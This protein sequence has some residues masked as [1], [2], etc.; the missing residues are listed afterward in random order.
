MNILNFDKGLS[1]YEA[2]NTFYFDLEDIATNLGYA[3]PKTA[4]QDF[5]RR[6]ADFQS[7]YV[8]HVDGRKLYDESTIYFFL[9]VSTQRDARE[10]LKYICLEVLPYV[11]QVGV[12]A[13]KGEA[14]RQLL[15]SNT[16]TPALL[17]DLEI[18]LGDEAEQFCIDNHYYRVLGYL[19]PSEV[20]PVELSVF[21]KT[22]ERLGIENF[23]TFL[24]P[25]YHNS[26]TL[27][28]KWYAFKPGQFNT[29]E[30]DTRS[31]RT[32]FLA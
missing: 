26:Y 12:K 20:S 8:A 22:V 15:A 30:W 31:R 21:W 14:V 17:V 18:V 25:K 6:N 3:R 13:I 1:L 28:G 32:T 7:R 11:R 10:W 27:D 29:L 24:C 16:Q 4:I 23:D 9:G 2:N 5:L 19:P